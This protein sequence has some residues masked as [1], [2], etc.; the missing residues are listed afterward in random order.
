MRTQ[1]VCFTLCESFREI[2]ERFPNKIWLASIIR[3]ALK[4]HETPAFDIL[5]SFRSLWWEGGRRI[6]TL[7]ELLKFSFH[8][9][10]DGKSEFFIPF[11]MLATAPDHSCA[12]FILTVCEQTV[13]SLLSD[14]SFVRQISLHI[15]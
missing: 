15:G 3:I 8:V 14:V 5:W 4:L 13:R 1:T 11:R 7:C 9:F 10:T 2:H 6:T 12:A